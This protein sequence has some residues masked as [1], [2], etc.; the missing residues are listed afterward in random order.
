MILLGRLHTLG[1]S[2]PLP[3]ASVPEG[4]LALF[5]FV[6]CAAFAWCLG[7]SDP[8]SFLVAAESFSSSVDGMPSSSYSNQDLD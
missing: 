7:P 1:W 6:S 5:P 4:S 2:Y 8:Q 3:V